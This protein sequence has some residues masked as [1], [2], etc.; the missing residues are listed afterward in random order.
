MANSDA[1]LLC[2]VLVGDE[3]VVGVVVVVDVD[4]PG[5]GVEL[6]L[7][8]AILLRVEVG[9]VVDC[10]VRLVTSVVDIT[11]KRGNKKGYTLCK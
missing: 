6:V 1:R 5:L 10:R 9:V 2:D 4:G 11:I 7:D 8:V 3:D